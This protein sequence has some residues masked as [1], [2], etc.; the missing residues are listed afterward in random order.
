MKNVLFR[1]YGLTFGTVSVC[2]S[3]VAHAS[4]ESSLMTVQSRL[5]N[6]ILPLA[7]IVGLVIAALSFVAGHE[8]ARGRLMLAIMGAVIGFMAPSIISFIQSMVN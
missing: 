4:V 2:L 6:T 3:L 5:I 8:N 1:F 7:G